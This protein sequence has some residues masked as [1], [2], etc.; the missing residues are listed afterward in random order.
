[1]GSEII[2]CTLCIDAKFHM[3][4]VKK[5]MMP[6]NRHLMPVQILYCLSLPL[7]FLSKTLP[8][9]LS[10]VWKSWW[11]WGMNIL[12]MILS[13]ERWSVRIWFRG[14]IVT[15]TLKTRIPSREKWAVYSVLR[16]YSTSIYTDRTK[17]EIDSG[18]G[19]C[20]R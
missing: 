3:P 5:L 1:M 10:Y 7:I 2:Y 17:T 13:W 12:D 4:K 16:D 15:K 6:L 8:F 18:F 20:F 11:N 19:L 14:L 9:N